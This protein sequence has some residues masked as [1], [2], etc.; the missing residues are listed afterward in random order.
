MTPT[1]GCYPP[2]P[3]TGFVSSTVPYD[4]AVGVPLNITVIIQFNQAMDIGSL[5][6]NIKV[7]GTRVDYAMDYDPETH[8]VEIGFLRLLERGT[9]V[10]VEIKRSVKNSCQQRQNVSVKFE[11]VT[12]GK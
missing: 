5:Y 6:K 3:G 9:K 2:D 12:V 11:F 10:T 4:G 8:Q 7:F 1:S